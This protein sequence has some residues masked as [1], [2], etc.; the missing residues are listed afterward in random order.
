MGLLDDRPSSVGHCMTRINGNAVLSSGSGR[1]NSCGAK[2]LVWSLEA[3]KYFVV[4]SLA[5]SW[6]VSEAERR[7]STRAFGS[8]LQFILSRFSK[9]NSMAIL[10][11]TPRTNRKLSV[12]PTDVNACDTF[13]KVPTASKAFNSADWRYSE[14]GQSAAN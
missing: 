3:G 2:V 1:N 14:D 13:R 8:L 12:T 11:L 9:R 6:L 10:F 7:Y 4:R 5:I